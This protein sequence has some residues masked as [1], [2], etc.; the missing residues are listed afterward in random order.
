[1][2]ATCRKPMLGRDSMK[3]VVQLD[4]QSMYLAWSTS[5]SQ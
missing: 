5:V 4:N 2:E 3:E 1:M